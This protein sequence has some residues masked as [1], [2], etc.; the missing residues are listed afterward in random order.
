M[1]CPLIAM[2]AATLAVVCPPSL[3]PQ[4]IQD[5]NTA[6]GLISFAI[7]IGVWWQVRNVR[8]SFRSRAQL[9]S[10]TEKLTLSLAALDR[11]LEEP[12]VPWPPLRQELLSASARL[13]TA[14][15][16]ATPESREIAKVA[17]RD[18]RETVGRVD[19][20]SSRVAV[21]A[22]DGRNAL[23]RALIHLSQASADL[24]WG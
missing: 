3:I 21:G 14:L 13:E 18:I 9:P 10:I 23:N 19:L 5:I 24:Q 1:Q 6:A 15:P 7:T 11:M 17:I 22:D 2:A 12:A 16:F 20:D 8:L 4:W